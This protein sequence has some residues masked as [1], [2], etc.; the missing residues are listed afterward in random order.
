MSLGKSILISGIRKC[1]HSPWTP[2][3]LCRQS[4]N[5]TL[6]LSLVHSVCKSGHNGVS[7]A[8]CR[9][10]GPNTRPITIAQVHVQ[11]QCRRVLQRRAIRPNPHW[12][13]ARKFAC[14]SIDG[15][16][17][18][19]EHFHSWQQ[20]LFACAAPARPVW[21]LPFMTAGTI[22]LRCVCASSVDTPIH[23]SRFYLLA[24]HLHVQCGSGRTKHLAQGRLS[25]VFS[26]FLGSTPQKNP[27]GVEYEP[28]TPA[29]PLTYATH[30]NVPPGDNLVQIT[31][32]M[33]PSSS[34]ISNV[35]TYR[36]VPLDPNKQNRVKMYNLIYCKFQIKCAA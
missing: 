8:M 5:R 32:A 25:L 33:S 34:R 31:S 28:R 36:W 13:R 26:K 3:W 1:I 14:K 23:D 18:Q 12:T 19:C 15:A 17:V 24:L 35:W 27:T 2:I 21:T 20:V 6:G 16:C 10:F 29:F 7:N 4:T 11:V 30:T 22:C 9:N